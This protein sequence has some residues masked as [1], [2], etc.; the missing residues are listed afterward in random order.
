MT[1]PTDRDSDLDTGGDTAP[2]TAFDQDTTHLNAAAARE[3]EPYEDLDLVEDDAALPW[4][5]TDYDDDPAGVDTGRIV[6]F[7]LLSLVTLALILAAIWYFLRDRADPDLQP[8]GTTIAAPEGPIRE[9]PADAGGQTFEGTGN[10]A[11]TVGEGRGTEG[12]LAADEPPRPS[13]SSDTPADPAKTAVPTE[14]DR[15]AV[16]GVPV[17]VGAYSTR[18]GATA[19]WATLRGQTDALQDFRH[20]IVEGQVDGGTVYRLQAMA[21]DASAANRL[22]DDLKNDGIACQVKR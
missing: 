12:R 1:A 17:Q 19:A 2:R 8:E 11:P 15:A 7:V 14:S 16:T 20:R 6:G 10:V 22:C 13:T 4:L 5:E 3:H 18:D 21:G 9:R